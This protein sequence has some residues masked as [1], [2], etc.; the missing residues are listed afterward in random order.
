V[1]ED[2][3]DQTANLDRSQGSD[4][5]ISPTVVDESYLPGVRIWPVK[6][7]ARVHFPVEDVV[8]E[9]RYNDCGQYISQAWTATDQ[10]RYLRAWK[11]LSGA[12]NVW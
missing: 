11:R 6:C 10:C 5:F 2:E 12:Q 8:S 3:E 7:G 9:H 1:K 4:Q